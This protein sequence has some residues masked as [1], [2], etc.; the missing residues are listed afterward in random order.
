[1]YVYDSEVTIEG[2]DLVDNS[3]TWAGDL[4]QGGGLYIEGGSVLV[5][6]N[7]ITSNY[8][9]GF[10]GFPSD[11][12][13]WG[14]GM[15]ISGSMAIVQDNLIEDNWATKGEGP[16]IGGGICGVYGTVQHRQKRDS[17]EPGLAGVDWLWRRGVRAADGR[18][19]GCQHN[20]GQCR[21]R[22]R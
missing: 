15:M 8:G 22:R 13:G 1:M 5:E 6:D 19:A 11:A 16:G 3:A 2:N 12:Q 17:R 20:H 18:V 21:G 10:P 4:G 14:G 9:A 7:D